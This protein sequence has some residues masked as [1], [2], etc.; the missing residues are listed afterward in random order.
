MGWVF[1]NLQRQARLARL[2]T[3]RTAFF[4]VL[5]EY[6]VTI[7]WMKIQDLPLLVLLKSLFYGTFFKVKI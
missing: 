2:A 6:R 7:F 4:V 5:L 3:Q 1:G